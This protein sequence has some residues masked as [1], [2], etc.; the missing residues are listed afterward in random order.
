MKNI[1]YIPNKSNS[2]H[3]HSVNE[4]D[5]ITFDKLDKAG[6]VHAFSTRTGGVSEGY[7]GSMKLS[8]HR[9]DDPDKVMENHR[10]FAKAVG[11]DHT[12]LVFS[13]DSSSTF[14]E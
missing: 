8:F 10:R 9:G 6:V 12:K 2:T 5:Y 1:K 14:A 11:Y 3:I 7:L 13:D 4:V